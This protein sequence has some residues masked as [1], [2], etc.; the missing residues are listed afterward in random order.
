MQALGS[1]YLRSCFSNGHSIFSTFLDP[2][3]SQWKLIEKISTFSWNFTIIVTLLLKSRDI[4]SG[5][6]CPQVYILPHFTH[7][8]KFFCKQEKCMHIF[9]FHVKY[10]V[11]NIIVH[12]V[13][14]TIFLLFTNLPNSPF[15]TRCICCFRFMLVFSVL[16]NS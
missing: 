12:L 7:I 2:F 8:P 13:I 10:F 4:L 5:L 3:E 16:V 14:H 15:K 1:E 9:L 11:K 6:P